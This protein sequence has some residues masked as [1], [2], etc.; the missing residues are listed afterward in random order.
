MKP[1]KIPWGPLELEHHWKALLNLFN[2]SESPSKLPRNAFE[3]TWYPR[4]PLRIPVKPLDNLWNPLGH[5]LEGPETLELHRAPMRPLETLLKP[6]ENSRNTSES[7][8]ILLW[9]SLNPMECQWDPR[10]TPGKPLEPTHWNPLKSPDTS[11]KSLEDPRNA[12]ETSWNVL[13]TLWN[14]SEI[15]WDP[16]NASKTPWNA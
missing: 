6:L 14:A 13:G 16:Y 1:P 3:T 4:K 9:K 2:A 10:N 11:L 12:P 5:P 7:L 15:L 8:G